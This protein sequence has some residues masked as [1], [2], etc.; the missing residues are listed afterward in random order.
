MQSTGSDA[1]PPPTS[2]YYSSQLA[3]SVDHSNSHAGFAQP[4]SSFHRPGSTVGEPTST[5]GSG[6]RYLKAAEGIQLT[7]EEKQVS[8]R[9]FILL[10]RSLPVEVLSPH[11][12]LTRSRRFFRKDTTTH[13]YFNLDLETLQLLLPRILRLNKLLQI[14]LPFPRALFLTL[15]VPEMIQPER[16]F[17]P[18]L[19]SHQKVDKEKEEEPRKMESD[20]T[21]LVPR[22]AHIINR[23]L[24]SETTANDE[25]RKM[26]RHRGGGNENN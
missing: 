7:Q 9:F 11:S 18:R 20:D 1:V 4:R 24:E 22:K 16:N 8:L 14:P 21:L 19:S 3:S 15:L 5:I 13:R 25:P 23:A 12:V 17:P 2:T 26:G 6:D 10:S